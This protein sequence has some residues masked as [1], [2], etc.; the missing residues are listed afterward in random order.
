MP[1]LVPRIPT[2]GEWLQQHRALAFSYRLIGHALHGA[3]AAA[4]ASLAAFCQ[5]R[6]RCGRIGIRHGSVS[7]NMHALWSYR[8]TTLR[9]QY[10]P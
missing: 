10:A 3:I 5:T 6:I 8:Y 9:L 2:F 7:P 4:S 1:A